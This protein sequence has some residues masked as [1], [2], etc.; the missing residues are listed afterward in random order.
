MTDFGRRGCLYVDRGDAQTF[1]KDTSAFTIDGTWHDLDLSAIV[2]AGAYVI[3]ISC[4]VRAT[5]AAQVLTFRENGNTKGNNALT[6]R[7]QVAAVSL[8][9]TGLVACNA[10]RII[11]YLASNVTVDLIRLNIIGWFLRV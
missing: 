5:A 3:N 7:T 9:F 6:A 4:Y 10:N 1:D 2:P 11:E 8:Q